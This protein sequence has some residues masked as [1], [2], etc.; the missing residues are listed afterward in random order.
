M[1]VKSMKEPRIATKS[2]VTNR[3]KVLYRPHPGSVFKRRFLADCVVINEDIAKKIG[4]PLE[5]LK[6]F[7]NCQFDLDANFAKKIEFYSGISACVWLH[8]QHHYDLFSASE[9][10]NKE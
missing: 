10:S 5:D 7:I 8:Y 3:D 4:V 2:N 6:D 9:H 1:Y